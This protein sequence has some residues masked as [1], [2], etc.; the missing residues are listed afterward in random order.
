MHFLH[1]VP[2]D[3]G[4]TNGETALTSRALRRPMYLVMLSTPRDWHVGEE[5]PRRRLGRL[6]PLHTLGQVREK[7]TMV[8][9]KPLTLVVMM[10]LV[11]M[12]PRK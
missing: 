2:I 5:R 10:L 4:Q 3:E 8:S 9:H 1:P 11:R 7:R 12:M 6:D